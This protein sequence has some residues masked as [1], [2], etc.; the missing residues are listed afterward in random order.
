MI[1]KIDTKLFREEDFEDLSYLIQICNRKYRHYI[2]V[3]LSELSGSF[4]EVYSK[5]YEIDQVIIVEIFER[6]IQEGRTSPDIRITSTNIGSTCFLLGEGIRYLEQPLCLVVENSENDG[7]FLDA[8]F[9][10]FKKAS[11][12]I[13]RAK[14]NGWLVYDMGGGNGIVNNINAKLRAFEGFLKT[15]AEYLRCYVIMDS[16]RKFP[17]MPLSASKQKII[18]FLAQ[19]HIPYHIL[20]KREIENYLPDQVV[21]T[22]TVDRAFVEAYLDLTPQQKDFFDLEMGFNNKNLD[23]LLPEVRDLYD[24]LPSDSSPLRQPFQFDNFKANFVKLFEQEE[25]N[26]E[27]LEERTR[28]QKDPNELL[29]IIEKITK[30]L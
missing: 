23:S 22:I 17:E 2:F 14:K 12:K 7:Y 27:T 30:L 9:R 28:H 18:D 8:I 21:D 6:L 3:E 1:V 13:Q 10:N 16:D 15:N 24:N 25:V 29:H 20:E 26:R 4:E 11:K 19:H 5:L